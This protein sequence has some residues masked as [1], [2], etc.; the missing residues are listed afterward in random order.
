M[1]FDPNQPIYLQ[2]AEHFCR[3]ILSKELAGAARI[4]SV[5]EI[6]ALTEVNPNTAMRAYH[7]LQEQ[8]IIEQQRGIGYFTTD[9][10]YKLVL[11]QQRREFLSSEL[12]RFLEKLEQLGYTPEDLPALVSSQNSR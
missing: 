4:P 11:E 10:A 2:I 12:P 1:K 9:N 8:G 3:Q 7:H 6:A 5:R